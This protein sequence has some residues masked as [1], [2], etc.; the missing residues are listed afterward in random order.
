MLHLK[1]MP[2]AHVIKQGEVG[3]SFFAGRPR[4]DWSWTG[5]KADRSGESRRFSFRTTF[6]SEF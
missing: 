4:S 5:L 6:G 1:Q 3:S 2:G